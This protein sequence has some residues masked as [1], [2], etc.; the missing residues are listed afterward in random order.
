[1]WAATSGGMDLILFNPSASSSVNGITFTGAAN[2]SYAV[3]A[4]QSSKFN[5][6]KR[7]FMRVDVENIFALNDETNRYTFMGQSK[8]TSDGTDSIYD[9]TL[10]PFCKYFTSIYSPGLD[11]FSIIQPQ[12]L[13]ERRT[14]PFT[15]EYYDYNALL[16]GSVGIIPTKSLWIDYTECNTTASYTGPISYY[17]YTG[18]AQYFNNSSN[19]IGYTWSPCTHL[20]IGRELV[21]FS[22]AKVTFKEVAIFTS[23]ISDQQALDFRDA[24]LARWP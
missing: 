20:F 8:R 16:S 6:M 24:M 2:N 15:A 1:V 4:N 19:A 21:D 13:V 11:F 12:G 14:G 22:K 7:I 3:T 9:T 5:V 23:S 17:N 10:S 18:S